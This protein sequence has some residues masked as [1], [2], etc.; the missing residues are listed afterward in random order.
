MRRDNAEV[1][2]Y[3]QYNNTLLD[4]LVELCSSEQDS[5][6]LCLG[7][8]QE[9]QIQCIRRRKSGPNLTTQLS[10]DSFCI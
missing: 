7:E 8:Y 9:W 4:S 10:L 6:R 2:K 3:L 5:Q 1:V